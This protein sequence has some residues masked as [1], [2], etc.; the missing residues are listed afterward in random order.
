MWLLSHRIIINFK[1]FPSIFMHFFSILAHYTKTRKWLWLIVSGCKCKIP[2]CTAAGFLIHG[3]ME[4][5]HKRCRA[6]YWQT[7][8]HDP[9]ITCGPDSLVGIVTGYG[10]TVRGSNPGGSEIFRTCPDRPWGPPNLLYNMYRVFPGGQDRPGRDADSS[11]TSS[12][13]GH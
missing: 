11:P 4:R 3:K 12:A 8:I 9:N 6:L 13:V 10:W 1:K 7:F 5:I 2:I